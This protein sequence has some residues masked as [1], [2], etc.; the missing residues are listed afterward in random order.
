MYALG[1]LIIMS[2]NTKIYTLLYRMKFISQEEYFKKAI[3]NTQ[4]ISYSE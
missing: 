3:L 2:L 4:S 1:E